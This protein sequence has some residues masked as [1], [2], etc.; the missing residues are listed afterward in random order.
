MPFILTMAR[1]ITFLDSKVNTARHHRTLEALQRQYLALRITFVR[2]EYQELCPRL[3]ILLRQR[4]SAEILLDASMHLKQGLLPK[5]TFALLMP[6]QI[7]LNDSYIHMTFDVLVIIGVL[8]EFRIFGLA[9]H[10]NEQCRLRVLVFHLVQ[11][12]F[13]LLAV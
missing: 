8:V 1:P 2:A 7:L 6:I 11:L 13:L 12:Q 5:L 4:T 9:T 3:K 10:H